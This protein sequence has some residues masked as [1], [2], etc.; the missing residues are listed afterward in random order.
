MIN[1]CDWN[2]QKPICITPSMDWKGLK[3]AEESFKLI[4]YKKEVK[5]LKSA[6]K[7]GNEVS[8]KLSSLG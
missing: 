2:N 6:E 4:K 8:R 7:E 5:G 1:K 3:S